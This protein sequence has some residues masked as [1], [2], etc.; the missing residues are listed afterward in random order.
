V[1]FGDLRHQAGRIAEANFRRSPVT[2]STRL[3]FHPRR[4]DLDRARGGEHLARHRVT[5]A[6]HQTTAVLIPLSRVRVDVRG[7]LRLRRRREHPPRAAAVSLASAPCPMVIGQVPSFVVDTNKNDVLGGIGLIIGML[8]LGPLAF[9][10]R[11]ARATPHT[12]RV[13]HVNLQWEP[14]AVPVAT[15]PRSFDCKRS[16]TGGGWSGSCHRGASS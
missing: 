16:A 4:T 3:S 7:D 11:R 14:Y 6:H 1:I 12:H 10:H 8:G 5:V 9:G 15:E 2:S 13:Y